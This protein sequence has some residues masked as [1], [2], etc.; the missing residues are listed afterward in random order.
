MCLHANEIAT[1]SQ[2][3]GHCSLRESAP[4][5]P[6]LEDAPWMQG[7]SRQRSQRMH[8]MQLECQS[9]NDEAAY[10]VDYAPGV[11]LNLVFHLVYSQAEPFHYQG[12]ELYQWRLVRRE[13]CSSG[14]QVHI[15]PENHITKMLTW[16]ER[17]TLSAHQVS[18]DLSG[19]VR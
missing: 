11:R 10:T 15:Y 3:E 2:A 16:P 6:P 19:S 18:L 17:S 1:R 7:A 8:C 12:Q 5:C 14:C 4:G 9:E 13:H